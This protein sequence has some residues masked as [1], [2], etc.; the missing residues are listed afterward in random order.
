MGRRRSDRAS[1]ATTSP[2]DS[3]RGGK[4]LGADG[5]LKGAT[6]SSRRLISTGSGA[7]ANGKAPPRPSKGASSVSTQRWL[8]LMAYFARFDL[9]VHGQ[10]LLSPV[11]S[12]TAILI[13]FNLQTALYPPQMNLLGL[14]RNQNGAEPSANPPAISSSGHIRSTMAHLTPREKWRKAVRVI[15]QRNILGMAVRHE[16]KQKLKVCSEGSTSPGL[17]T[18]LSTFRSR[19]QPAPFPRP[20]PSL[21]CLKS[22]ASP[23]LT[24]DRPLASHPSPLFRRRPASS[25]R[26]SRSPRSPPPC[27]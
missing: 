12:V 21:P 1:R 5:L 6:H 4:A 9:S 27:P 7:M 2:G 25:P 3:L 16:Q 17:Q 19:S 20:L 13:R 24:R 10:A 11:G 15:A 23:F 8:W 14:T 18:L 26:T 22:R